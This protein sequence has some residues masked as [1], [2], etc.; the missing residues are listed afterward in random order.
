MVIGNAMG[1][2][3]EVVQNGQPWSN[4]RSAS[5]LLES[6]V[7]RSPIFITHFLAELHFP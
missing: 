6:G 5:G 4:G 1:R 7:P 2:K 3:W